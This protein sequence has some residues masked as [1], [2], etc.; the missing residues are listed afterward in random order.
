MLGVGSLLSQEVVEGK[1]V[2]ANMVVPI[3]LLAP[4]FESL[5]M[6][7]QSGKPPRPW[8]GLYAAESDGQVLVAGMS[9][10]GPAHKAGLRPE[11]LIVGVAGKRVGT[12]AAFLRAVW[13]QGDAGIRIPLMVGRGGDLLRVELQS[14]DRND[15]LKRPSLH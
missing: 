3:D 12:L 13:E 9:E 10:G 8:L 1:N 7:G 2:N 4:I 15:L 5:L 11:D 6:T 14:I